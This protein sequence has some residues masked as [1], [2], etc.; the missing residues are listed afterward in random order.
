VHNTFILVCIVMQH[1]TLCTP[2]IAFILE[3][4]ICIFAIDN[5]EPGREETPEAAPVEAGNYEQDQGKPQCI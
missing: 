1:T 4:H 5:A 3:S 2:C